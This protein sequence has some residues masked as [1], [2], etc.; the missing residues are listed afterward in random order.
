MTRWAIPLMLMLML[1]TAALATEQEDEVDSLVSP[2]VDA[3]LLLAPPTSTP[4]AAT[5]HPV[6]AFNLLGQAIEPGSSRTL[7]WYSSQL[8]GAFEVPV[9]VLVVHGLHSG[10]VVCLTSAIHGDEL[11][12]IEINRRVIHALEPSTI[13]GTVISIPVVNLSGFWRTDRYLSDRRDLNRYFP[14]R[15][16]GSAASQLAYQL[17]ELIIRNCDQLVD[18]HTGSMAR[19]NLPQLRADLTL[20]AV[21]QMVKGFG[22]ISVL[23]SLGPTG[24]LRGAAT[25]AGI[26]AV[27]ME[28]GGPM[29]LDTRLVEQG[30]KS[31]RNY[32][33]SI[34]VRPRQ[35]FFS[36]P[37]PVF[38]QSHWVRASE[39]GILINQLELGSRVKRGQLL[40]EI[41]DPI[42]NI[43]IEIDAPF[44]GVILGRARN[45]FV[46]PGYA[47]YH[48]G[49]QRSL[50][51]LERQAEQQKQSLIEQQNS[52][53]DKGNPGAAEAA[54][55]RVD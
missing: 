39:G 19:E 45:Q 15:E 30:V 55:D 21:A 31:L 48:I 26:P 7:H 51:E 29:T 22:A 27:V 38:Y 41:H 54:P 5:R 16:K 8:P 13:R 25:R 17:F 28:V 12:G 20:A 24:S 44:D 3:P 14:G 18:L 50:E 32:L 37:Q 9:P 42:R 36:Q 40:G 2:S 49:K 6:Q 35:V 10:P 47:L 1:T 46:S 23:Q 53:L 34:G 4:A 52:P 11:N 33:S 43:T